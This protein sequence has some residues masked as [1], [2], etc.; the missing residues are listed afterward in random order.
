VHWQQGQAVE[1][2][3]VLAFAA[4]AVGF[5]VPNDYVAAYVSQHP[6]KLIGF[7]SVDPATPTPAELRS[8][9]SASVSRAEARADLPA[10]R[11]SVS[12]PLRSTQLRRSSGCPS[13]GTKGRRSYATR[14]SSGR[15]P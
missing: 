15:A 12:V 8:A 13:C 5:V 9:V 1:H 6:E 14:H 11:P 7:A 10:F 3:I 4:P 2:A